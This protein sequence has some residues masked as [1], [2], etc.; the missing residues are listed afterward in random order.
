MAIA[1]RSEWLGFPPV[2]APGRPADPARTKMLRNAL[3]SM[4]SDPVGKVVLE[5][6]KLDGFTPG[7]PALFDGIAAKVARL[8]GRT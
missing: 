6:L 2:A 3:V 1:R 8:S 4:G 7:T 5:L